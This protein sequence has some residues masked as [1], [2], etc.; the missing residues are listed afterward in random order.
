MFTYDITQLGTPLMQMRMLLG[1]T[2]AAS[3][4][5]QDE[6]LNA[7]AAITQQQLAGGFNYVFGSTTIQVTAEVLLVACAN[8]LDALAARVASG[9][10][11]Q[12]IQIGDFNLTGSSQVEKLQEMAE[13]F[14]EA[15]NNVPAWGIV[16]E[17]LSGFNELTIMR[18]WVLR[19]EY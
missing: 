16:E 18:N 10:N 12:D 8:A 6:E 2:N 13:K 15:V 1:D 9:P 11:G 4:N 5:W 14:R 7:I 17:N 3:P 19:T